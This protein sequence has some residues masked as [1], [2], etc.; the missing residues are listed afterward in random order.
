LNFIVVET[1]DKEILEI[2]LSDM[3]TASFED[4]KKAY[5]YFDPSFI[6]IE[7]KENEKWR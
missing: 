6:C 4:L 7:C 2:E 5:K 3:E 1:L